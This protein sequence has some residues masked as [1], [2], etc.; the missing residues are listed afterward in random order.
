MSEVLK[1][2]DEIT[3]PGS[4]PTTSLAG[5]HEQKKPRILC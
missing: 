1:T 5:V 3:Y 4:N 2:V